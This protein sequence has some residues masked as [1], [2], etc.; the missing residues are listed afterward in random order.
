[1]SFY[2]KILI[3]SFSLRLGIG[4]FS[5]F[6]TCSYA[7]ADNK[8]LERKKI[9]EN[10]EK[11]LAY[12]NGI[13]TLQADLTQ[14]DP[15]GTVQ[16][17]VLKISRPGLMRLNYA[18]PSNTILICDG[19]WMIVRDPLMDETTYLPLEDTPASLLLS[20]PLTI[21]GNI[22]VQ[23]ARE[24]AALLRVQLVPNDDEK[25]VRLTLVFTL[26][27][28][29]LRQWIAQDVQGGETIVTLDNLKTGLSFDSKLFRY[30]QKLS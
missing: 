27:P 1:M 2:L 28:F 22:D 23:D 8:L 24:E 20:H 25:V 15:D 26:Q 19:T 3:R 16:Q 30:S 14:V 12:I 17:G 13:T 21:D 11:A 5:F 9:Q 6:L 29:Q 18:K 4:F 10:I 7:Q